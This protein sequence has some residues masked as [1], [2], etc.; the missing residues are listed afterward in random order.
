MIRESHVAR[1]ALAALVLVAQ[2]CGGIQSALDPGGAQ[3][4][5]VAG[6][7]WVLLAICTVVYAAVLVALGLAFLRRARRPDH[8]LS[9]APEPG[10]RA[11]VGGALAL[12]VLILVGLV[13][14]SVIVGR[15]VTRLPESETPPLKVEIVG[16]QWWWQVRYLDEAANR[17]FE[18]AN[19]L[20][21]P[22]GRLVVVELTARDVIHS[23]WVPSL[24]GKVDLIPGRRNTL[25]FVADRPGEFRGQCAEFCGL[26]H[27]KMGLVVV[28][29]PADEYEAWAEASRRPAR[30]PE[31]ELAQRGLEVFTERASCSTC[32]TVRGTGAWGRVAPD[33][34]RIGSRRT[35]AAGSLPNTRGNLAGWILDPQ[36]V[37]PGAFMPPS[38]LDPDDL[39]ALVAYLEGLR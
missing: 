25:W 13:G 5:R 9:P 3:A 31:S 30:A 34:T 36:H 37:K 17:G 35:L 19:E 32:H 29:M 8:D 38:A 20:R 2:G 1:V 16:R 18:T 21:V 7:W 6:L 11:V 22:V 15:A 27:A 12:T 24:H 39:Q 26:Q 4:Q 14:Y 33:L 23:Y 10:K 28:A